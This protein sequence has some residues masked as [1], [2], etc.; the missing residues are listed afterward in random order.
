MLLLYAATAAERVFGAEQGPGCKANKEV[1]LIKRAI[2]AARK[3][4]ANN[5][6]SLL[7]FNTPPPV[8]L[9]WGVKLRW[10]LGPQLLFFLTPA[11]STAQVGCQIKMTVS[12]FNTP[13]LVPL[14]WGVKL[15]DGVG[16]SEEAPVAGAEAAE[17]KELLAKAA[18]PRSIPLLLP[19]LGDLVLLLYAATVCC[20]CMLLLYAARLTYWRE[21]GQARAR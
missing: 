12:L 10:V 17:L 11:F 16:G 9:H 2:E 20:Y 7:P 15:R 8:P 4:S 21:G 5:N 6:R 3:S 18:D 14:E 13:P 19:E 1:Q